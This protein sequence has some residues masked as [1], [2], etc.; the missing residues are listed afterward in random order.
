M[1]LDDLARPAIAKK[2]RKEKIR[3]P[4]IMEN[5]D[6]YMAALDIIAKTNHID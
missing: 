3:L 1:S 5:M 6:K 2:L 4:L